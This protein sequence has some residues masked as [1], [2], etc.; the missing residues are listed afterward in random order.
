MNAC[1]HA[2]EPRADHGYVRLLCHVLRE[3]P[4]MAGVRQTWSL[5]IRLNPSGEQPLDL[6]SRQS[7]AH[8][9]CLPQMALGM[10]LAAQAKVDRRSGLC[11]AAWPP[12]LWH[13]S[14][15]LVHL[16]ASS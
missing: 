14:L 12:H 1:R 16:F 9:V 3:L 2:R 15:R 8:L 5:F 6:E 10:G 13:R 11:K 4:A 7:P